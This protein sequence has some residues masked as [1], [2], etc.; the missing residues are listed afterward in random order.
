MDLRRRT[1]TF[2][3][4]SECWFDMFYNKIY[5][6]SFWNSSKNLLFQIHCPIVFFSHESLPPLSIYCALIDWIATLL[7]FVNTYIYV[8][9]I[10]IMKKYRAWRLSNNENKHPRRCNYMHETIA[11]VADSQH[12]IQIWNRDENMGFINQVV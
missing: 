4:L 12:S 8:Y 3:W 10:I 11:M 2:E 9:K 7:L 6:S 1:C 5:L